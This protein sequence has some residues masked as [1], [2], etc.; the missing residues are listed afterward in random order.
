MQ[1]IRSWVG[2]NPN[3]IDFFAT[4]HADYCRNS[5]VVRLI[6]LD[7]WCHLMISV[8]P[9]LQKKCVKSSMK[10]IMGGHGEVTVTLAHWG[11]ETIIGSDNGLS[12]GRSQAIIWT[13]TGLLWI[14][15]LG[16]YF[17][18]IRIKIQQF[19]LKKIHL[20]MS[21]GKCRPSCLGLN[22][23]ICCWTVRFSENLLQLFWS[24]LNSAWTCQPFWITIKS[25]I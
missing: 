11:W 18:E 16:T 23:L 20:K 14:G 8:T 4:F 7:V 21:S 10:G 24:N 9:W 1:I 15:P 25:L 5:D 12:P 19:S 17:N 6:R 13:N 22:V 3:L 2:R